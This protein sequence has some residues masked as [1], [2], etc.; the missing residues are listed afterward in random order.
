MKTTPSAPIR[1]EDLHAYVDG[2]LPEARRLAV[3]AHL[4]DHPEDAARVA[5]W[6]RDNEALREWLA[7][8]AR[9]AIPM[10]IPTTRPAAAWRPYALA[11]S[12]A[13]VSATAGWFARGALQAPLGADGIAAAHAAPPF[14]RRAAVAHVVYSPEVRRPVEVGAEHEDQ[15]IAWLS[16]RMDAPIRPPD[17]RKSG[18]E[19]I[20]GRLL[21]G[22]RGP[23]AQFMYHDSTGQRLTLYVARSGEAG[24]ERAF[25]FEQSGPVNLFY[26]MDE[27]FGYAIAA[28]A[29]R[30]ELERVAVDV[31]RQLQRN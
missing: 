4:R 10:R 1:E 12:L 6:A 23:A 22:E 16:R 21:P 2:Q 27:T 14:A 3:E 11:A 9:E 5:A 15:L 26:W 8:V 30:G 18:F 17:L 24:G 20:G 25:R 29:P 13:I 28:G 7:P 19:L 31:H